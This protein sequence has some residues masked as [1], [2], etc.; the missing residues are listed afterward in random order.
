MIEADFPNFPE[1]QEVLVVKPWMRNAFEFSDYSDP[2]VQEF[3]CNHNCNNKQNC[4]HKCCKGIRRTTVNVTIKFRD[5]SESIESICLLDGAEEEPDA[6]GEL[7][8]GAFWN[9]PTRLQY[10]IPESV[11]RISS[12]LRKIDYIYDLSDQSDEEDLLDENSSF[13][14][15]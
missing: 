6:L 1:R 13:I 12:Q 7:D 5:G 15:Y 4:K 10:H 3:T 11:T 14:D 8:N 9:S 2:H